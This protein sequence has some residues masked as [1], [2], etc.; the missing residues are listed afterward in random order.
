[1]ECREII[2]LLEQ[3]APGAYSEEWDNVGLLVG[4]DSKE[5]K[6][7]MVA[8]DCTENV[9]DQAVRKEADML[10]T[11][12]PLIFSPMKR[13]NCNDYIGRKVY[14]LASN[15][16]A[17]F[18][19]HTNMDAAVMADESARMLG[20][21]NTR[22]LEV[23]YSKKVYKLAVYVPV[24]AADRVRDA[25]TREGAGFIGN[26]SHCTYNI[27]GTGTFKANEGCNP[28]VG[29]INELTR[30]SEIKIETVITDEN[31]QRVVRAMLKAHPYEEVAYDIYELKNP[32]YE[33]GIG[34]IGYLENDMTLQDL[35]ALVKERFGIA[36]VN[37]VGN[38]LTKVVTAAICPGSGKSMIKHA[39]KA[40]VNVLITGDID[41]HNAIDAADQGLCIIDAGHFG[42]EHFIVE[43]IRN[44]LVR[45]VYSSNNDLFSNASKLEVMM[46]AETSPFTVF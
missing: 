19:A 42:T 36:S 10:I 27:D 41:H 21:V 35:A 46:A 31:M 22:P 37:V 9:I 16:I 26:Y 5:V 12:H 30:T 14:K 43:Y 3:L 7:V 38:L 45:S 6:R 1:M 20:M 44:Y 13:V 17:Y 11:H 39:L 2:K 32:A 15:D 34:K 25:I 29:E 23:T 18:A 8:L 33:K 28:F 40:G 24:P 4:R